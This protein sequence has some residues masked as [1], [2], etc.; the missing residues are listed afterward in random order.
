MS[1]RNLI[2][3]LIILCLAGLAFLLSRHRKAQVRPTDPAVDDLAGAI[4]A[5]KLIQK[6]AHRPPATQEACRGA[7]EGMVRQVDEY[8]RYVLPGRA[9]GFG[10]RLDGMLE[11]TGLEITSVGEKL[12]TLGPLPM[13]PAH[14]AEIF[15]GS[16]VLAIDG[17][18]AKYLSLRRARELLAGPAGKTVALRLRDA[19]GTELLRPIECDRFDVETVT[20]IV[21]DD[22]GRWVYTLD[23]KAGICYLRIGEFVE[24]TPRELLAAYRWL[25]RPE[26]LVL[27]LRGN[28]GGALAAAV[29]VAECFL[30]EGLIVRT[31]SRRAPTGRHAAHAAGTFPPAPLAVLIDGQTASGGEIVAGALQAHGRAVVVGQTSRG[32]WCVQGTVSL[33]HGL[34]QMYLT[35][36]EYFLAEPQPRTRP[37]VTTAATAPGGAADQPRPGVEPDVA[38]RLTARAVRELKRLRRR[39]MVLPPPRRGRPPT[40]PPH[41]KLRRSILDCDE[42]LARALRLLKVGEVPA[43]RPGTQPAVRRKGGGP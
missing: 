4:G 41:E 26:G 37:S 36:G 16:E 8:S 25:D 17:I 19:E 15:G 35:T 33:G 40:R 24:R 2:W 28:P 6:R 1:W 21:R 29:A 39:A 12:L 32:K 27:D 23:E 3:M 18:E 31:V 13:S 42:Q 43:T 34:G 9:R 11:G 7:I 38:V 10:R 14:A 20:G 22:T 30:S 5:Y